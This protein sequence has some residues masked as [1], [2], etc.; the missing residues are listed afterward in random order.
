M[1]FPAVGITGQALVTHADV[2]MVTFTGSTGTGQSILQAGAKVRLRASA[3]EC[4]GK[5]PQ[6]IFT[7]AFRSNPDG[8][9]MAMAQG[10]L[11]N[12]GQ[13]CVSRS[14][15]LVE[16]SVYDDVRDALL[17]ACSMMVPAPAAGCPK[18]IRATGE[19]A[20]V[21]KDVG[22]SRTRPGGGC[23]THPRWSRCGTGTRILRWT[24]CIP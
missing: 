22:L 18:P 24:L 5:C 4:G 12:Q 17:Q 23:R 11:W 21:R 3:L 13:V 19:Q 9:A 7:D 16:S 10:A 14:R 6:L 20:P 15:V 2:N 8:L 1:S